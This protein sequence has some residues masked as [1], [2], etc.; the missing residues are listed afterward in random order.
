MR[1]KWC[2]PSRRTRRELG[3]PRTLRAMQLEFVD[4]DRAMEFTLPP[5]ELDRIFIESKRRVLPL[6]TAPK[7]PAERED[8][9]EVELDLDPAPCASSS[10]EPEPRAL[11]PSRTRSRSSR[12]MLQRRPAAAPDRRRQRVSGL[13]VPEDIR[14]EMMEGIE[15]EIDPASAVRNMGRRPVSRA[16]IS[17][18]ARCSRRLGAAADCADPAPESRMVPSRP[19]GVR[20]DGRHR[21]PRR[22][23]FLPT[24]CASG[25]S[26]AIRMR[27]AP[28]GCAPAS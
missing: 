2:A 1:C 28:C 13:E 8:E 16:C 11:E 7:A 14:R 10:R 23:I 9:I 21:R 27:T 17:H 19:G 20:L 25:A 12:A 22:R 4:P 5:G 24:S 3:S 15:D 26:R 18:L 6:P